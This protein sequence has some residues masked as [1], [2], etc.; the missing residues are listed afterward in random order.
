MDGLKPLL[1]QG[2]KAVMAHAN[3]LSGK[4]N[5]KA[6]LQRTGLWIAKRPPSA[7][8]NGQT[9]R[10]SHGASKDLQRRRGGNWTCV[11]PSGQ[12]L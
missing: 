1:K 3:W 4:E 11:T 9:P 2:R 6:A 10:Q 7:A 5:K 12:L 8:G